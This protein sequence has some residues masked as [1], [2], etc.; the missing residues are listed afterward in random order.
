MDAGAQHLE[1]VA[2][3]QPVHLSI[4]HRN[5]KH[6]KPM[7]TNCKIIRL[8]RRNESCSAAGSKCQRREQNVKSALAA[9]CAVAAITVQCHAGLL[10]Y[11]PFDYTDSLP[12][13]GL[14]GGSGWGGGWL[15]VNGT[16]GF[17]YP[18]NLSAGGNAPANYD[19]RSIGNSVYVSDGNR[20]GRFLNTSPSGTFGSAGFLDANGNIGADGKTVYLSFMLQVNS[21]GSFYEF[22]FKRGSMSDGGRIGGIGNDNGTQDIYLRAGG[23][24]NYDLG[25]ANTTGVDFFVVRIDYKPGN[26]DVFVYRNPTS[27]TEPA[28]PT[29]VVSNSADMS[30]SGFSLASFGHGAPIQQDEI[31]LG[32]TWADVIGGPPEFI[33]QPQ[34]FLTRIGASNVLSA[35]A[36]SDQAVQYQWYHGTNAIAGATDTN[37][38]F[39]SIQASDAGNYTLVASNSL[40]VSATAPAKV[41]VLT[42]T[43]YLLAYEGFDYSSSVNLRGLNGGAGWNG[44]WVD[45]GSSGGG[46]VRSGSLA[47]A[48]N[49]PTGYDARATGNSGFIANGNRYGRK[50]DCSSAGTFGS[51]GLVDPYGRIGADGATVY[52]SFLQQPGVATNNFYELEFKRDSLDDP[53]RIG[54][55]G[56]DTGGGSEVNLRIQSPAGGSSTIYDL[57]AGETNVDLYVIRIDY[58]NGND[59]VTV[60]RNPTA[61]N[62]IDNVPIQTLPNVADMSF[63]GISMAA[64][65]NGCTLALDQF[66]VG[67]SWADAIGGPPG[68]IVQPPTATTAFTSKSVTLSALAASDAPINYQWYRNGSKLNGQTGPSLTLNNLQTPDGGQYY[69]TASNALGSVASIIDTLSIIALQITNQPQNQVVYLNQTNSATLVSGADGSQVAYQWFRNGTAVGG[70]TNS[71]LTLS[72]LQITNG[73]NYFIVASSG[74]YSVTS[75]I[76]SVTI[77]AENNNLFAYDGFAY[78]GSDPSSPTTFIDGSSQ[79]GGFGWN[80]PWQLQNGSNVNVNLGNLAGGTNVP[81]GFDFRSA[82]NSIENFGSCRIGRFFDTSTN[83]VLYKQGFVDTTGNIGAGGKTIYLSFLQQSSTTSSFYELELKRDD[84]GDGGRL[85]G[86][87]NDTGDSDVHYR[88]QV[89]PGHISTFYDLGPSDPNVVNFYVVRIDYNAV[90]ANDT[91]Y[92]YRNPSSVTEPSVPTMAI[93]NAGDV[94]LN[95]ITLAA[96]NGPD[97]KIDEIRLGATWA[98]AIGLAVSNLLPP[99]KVSNGY[100]IRFACTPGYSYRVQRATSAAGP[101]TDIATLTG[102]TNAYL[103]YT[104]TVAPPGQAFYRT[105]TP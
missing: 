54:G 104:D 43:N 39:S 72:G 56:N 69:V 12:L 35:V 90:P 22:E 65:L 5:P 8:Q 92:I 70:A 100:Q 19:S 66:R 49:A 76:A 44:G 27:A 14:N 89:P 98:D 82:T 47:A 18:G 63:N 6:L 23:V 105:V 41:S 13:A 48:A 73:G 11:E 86:I 25:P 103:E 88:V 68:F 28:A 45:V 15:N 95:G 1:A 7:K 101:W 52:I 87:G 91:I 21:N 37:L 38:V 62:E 74:S 32:E 78:P 36:V 40:G 81:P 34:S 59:S 93:T 79:N 16:G 77:Y 57:G 80:G 2:K 26:D 42:V 24:K 51:L 10:A 30:L 4:S 64:Y 53:G 75:S 71:S 9:L 99:T 102:P 20:Y 29:L 84:L 58:T 94:S 85:G 97:M 3:N 61:A 96:Y 50:L 17:T 31:R 67:L 46:T 33:V 83:S 60:Y 55:I